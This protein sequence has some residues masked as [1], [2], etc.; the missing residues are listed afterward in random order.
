MYTTIRVVLLYTVLLLAAV[1][2]ALPVFV[3]FSLFPY[4]LVVDSFAS[5][6]RVLRE[7]RTMT[8]RGITCRGRVI[9]SRLR[10]IK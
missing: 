4:P 7:Y 9:I 3:R 6:Q 8:R 10:A 5:V 2:S 1:L